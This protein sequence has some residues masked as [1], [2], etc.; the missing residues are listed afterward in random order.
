MISKEVLL[1]PCYAKLK[2]GLEVVAQDISREYAK[3]PELRLQLDIA[4][5]LIERG[6][7]SNE[8]RPVRNRFRH[9]RARRSLL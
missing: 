7:A 8:V 5:F 9:R 6:I 3:R 2:L 4:R 1:R